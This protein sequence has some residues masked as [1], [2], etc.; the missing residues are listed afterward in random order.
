MSDI[1][2]IQLLITFKRM[3]YNAT[4]RYVGFYSKPQGRRLYALS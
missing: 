1:V 3:N 4:G 2:N